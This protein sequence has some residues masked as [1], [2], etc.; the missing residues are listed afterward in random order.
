MNRRKLYLKLLQAVPGTLTRKQRILPDF[1]IIGAQKCGTSSIYFNLRKHKWIS[2]ALT[3][4]VHFFDHNY[5]KGPGW[6]R[7]HFPTR[8]Y[9]KISK[10]LFNRDIITGEASPDYINYYHVPQRIYN[11]I[12]GIKL[13]VILRN[14][15]DRAYSHYQHYYRQ[16]LE[17]LSFEEALECEERR[18]EGE[19]EKI[20]AD[21]NYYSFNYHHYSYKARGMYFEQLRKW[22]SIFP[23]EQFFI[24]SSEEYYRDPGSVYQKMLDFLEVPE[25]SP[26][27]FGKYNVGKKYNRMNKRTRKKLIEYFIPH[28]QKL[29][30]L[31]GERFEW[32]V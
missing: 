18:L 19:L 21:E 16:G 1:I 25:W 15:V 27:E 11:L 31:L 23:R 2:P 9:R 3:K 24:S 20:K 7:K 8:H 5:N 14:P 10:T 30:D 32:D 28:N 6:Y 22:I 26:K 12:P 17:E 4:E 29:Y 13:L